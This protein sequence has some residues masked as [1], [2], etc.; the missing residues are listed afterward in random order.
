M[1]TI[2]INTT[3]SRKRKTM[4]FSPSFDGLDLNISL[5]QPVQKADYDGSN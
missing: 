2:F 5:S 1:F 4:E 3:G